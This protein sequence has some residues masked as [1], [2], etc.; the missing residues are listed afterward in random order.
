MADATGPL[1]GILLT[2]SCSVLSNSIWRQV[3]LLDVFVEY[4]EHS[5]SLVSTMRTKAIQL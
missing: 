2:A 4:L 1:E 3:A 5:Q